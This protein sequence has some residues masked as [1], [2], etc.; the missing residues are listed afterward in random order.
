MVLVFLKFFKNE[1][2]LLPYSRLRILNFNKAVGLFLIGTRCFEYMEFI[3][4]GLL[5]RAKKKSENN[6]NP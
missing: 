2:F 3:T 5:I 6:L 4:C 1:S